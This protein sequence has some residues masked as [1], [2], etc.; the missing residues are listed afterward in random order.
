MIETDEILRL[1]PHRFPMLLVDRVLE[2][3]GEAVA[4]VAQKNVS[5]NEPFFPGHFPARPI[6]PGVLIIEAMAQAGLICIFS[7]NLVERG[8]DFIF[9]SIE[10]ARF[11]RAVVPGDQLRLEVKLLR[12][13]GN[14][15]KMEGLASVEG[16]TVAEAVITAVTAPSSK[17]P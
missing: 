6:M 4:I 14:Y 12:S 2:V 5:H 7:L 17:T 15:W 13:R 9:G 11:R 16:E 3:D 1:I 10:R 8:S